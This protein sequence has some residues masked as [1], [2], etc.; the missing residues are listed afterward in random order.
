MTPIIPPIVL[1][2]PTIQRCLWYQY[3]EDGAEWTDWTSYGTDTE[4]PWSWSF[5]G[6]DGYYEFYSIAVDDYGNVEEPPSTADTSTGLDMVPPVTT[7][8]LD[9]TMGENDWY[10]SSVTVTLSATD[11]LSGV[12]STWY[13]VDSGNWKIYTK[14][15][16]VSGDGHHTIY[17]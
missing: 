14:L 6:V 13:Q 8:I 1:P 12:E 11:E 5:T 16:T 4:A 3:S 9:G 15:F 7:I 2:I 10:V 17:Y